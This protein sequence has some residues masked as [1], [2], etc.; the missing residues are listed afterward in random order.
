MILLFPVADHAGVE[1]NVGVY[2]LAG[3]RIRSRRSHREAG[4]ERD[5]A[6]RVVAN[7][8]RIEIARRLV[9]LL[10]PDFNHVAETDL[11]KC[12]VPF[13]DPFAD[14]GAV[15]VGHRFFDPV[16]DLPFGRD[17]LVGILG[18]DRLGRLY[19]PAAY[20]A[21]ERGFLAVLAEV[22]DTSCAQL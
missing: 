12:L 15:L 7:I 18:V 22:L 4:V 3:E 1:N 21:D 17:Q 9:V 8:L 2:Q 19:T 16:D 20:V 5:P 14:V 11:L 10:L 13:E 6:E